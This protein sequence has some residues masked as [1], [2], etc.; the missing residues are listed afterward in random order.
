MQGIRVK[1]KEALWEAAAGSRRKMV[2][3][4]TWVKIVEISRTGQFREIL[5]I[6]SVRLDDQLD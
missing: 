6:E 3:R 1:S 2:V 5:E 4:W